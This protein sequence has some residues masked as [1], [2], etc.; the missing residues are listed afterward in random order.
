MADGR[1]RDLKEIV[2]FANARVALEWRNVTTHDQR[3]S[4][5]IW[6]KKTIVRTQFTENTM[7]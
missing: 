5:T 2:V 4:T 1:Q 7:K 6:I 3:Q